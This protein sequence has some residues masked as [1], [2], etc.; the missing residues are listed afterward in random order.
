MRPYILTLNG[1]GYRLGHDD[2]GGQGHDDDGNSCS[3]RDL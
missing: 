3:T 2:D 1:F